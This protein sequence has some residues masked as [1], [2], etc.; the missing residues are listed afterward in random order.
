MQ[1]NGKDIAPEHIEA[2]LAAMIGNFTYAS[3]Q[4]AMKRAGCGDEAYR[5]ADKLLQ[6]E[7]KAGRIQTVGSRTW[8][9]TSP[10]EISA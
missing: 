10:K 3:I 1:V 4:S 2:G 9:R 6:R 7:R 5:A 8:S